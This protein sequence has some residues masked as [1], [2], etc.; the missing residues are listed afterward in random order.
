MIVNGKSLLELA[1]IENMQTSKRKY[2]GTSYGLTEAGYDITIKQDIIF[3]PFKNKIEICS[4]DREEE[5]TNYLHGRFTIASAR[6]KFTMPK[7]LV[8]VVH[9]KSSWARRGL[10]V[11]NTVIEPG[12]NGYLT[13][14]LVYHG[15]ENLYISRGQGIAQVL[16]HKLTEEGDYGEGKYQN[17][18][19]KPVGTKHF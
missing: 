9:N 12:W 10:S 7:N 18:P 19:D 13:L 2:S 8:A 1:P 11:F 17:Q 4:E 5:V 15:N 3:F 14:E 6:E 16:F